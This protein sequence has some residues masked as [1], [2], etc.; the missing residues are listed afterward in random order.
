MW[1][2]IFFF[3]ILIAAPFALWAQT[4]SFTLDHNVFNPS[5]NGKVTLTFQTD[6]DGPG[7]LS[8]YDTAGELVAVLFPKDGSNEVEANH[9]YSVTWDG[10]NDAGHTVAS[11]V[12]LFHLSLKLGSYEKRLVVL[13]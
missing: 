11:G 8:V 5:V 4:P 3:S 6:Y 9:F 10:K 7:S 12:Y 1:K 2:V 13:M